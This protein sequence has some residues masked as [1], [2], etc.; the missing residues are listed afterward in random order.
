MH[1]E[2]LQETV[3]RI[4]RKSENQGDQLSAQR[5]ESFLMHVALLGVCMCVCVWRTTRTISI[6][7]AEAKRT[8]IQSRDKKKKHARKN[9]EISNH[10]HKEEKNNFN[11]PIQ[12][13]KDDSLEKSVYTHDID[14]YQWSVHRSSIYSRRTFDVRGKGQLPR[15]SSVSCVLM[16]NSTLTGFQ[17][18]ELCSRKCFRRTA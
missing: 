6:E 11:R 5:V 18:I 15:K 12:F 7:T 13:C 9:E 1:A 17:V 10:F 14:L 4:R 3:N 2:H 16:I 8:K